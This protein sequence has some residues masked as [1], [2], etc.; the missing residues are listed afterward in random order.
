MRSTHIPHGRDNRMGTS[1]WCWAL[2]GRRI[3]CCDTHDPWL[4][5]DKTA[6]VVRRPAPENC[7]SRLRRGLVHSRRHAGKCSRSIMQPCTA[8]KCGLTFFC[9]RGR[10][11]RPRQIRVYIRI[12]VVFCECKRVPN[13]SV[14]GITS[15]QKAPRVSVGWT[16]GG[17]WT[18][19]EQSPL[20]EWRLA[21]MYRIFVGRRITSHKHDPN[22]RIV[23]IYMAD[24][25]ISKLSCSQRP[26]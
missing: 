10:L 15:T 5:G 13:S 23:G 24:E 2:R 8:N 25:H 21:T 26:R 20:G 6:V 1:V 12:V 19:S 9:Y 17:S 4:R 14:K 18:Y 3:V 7:Q 16:N 11:S 22:S